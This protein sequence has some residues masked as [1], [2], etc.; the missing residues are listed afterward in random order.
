M[1]SDNFWHLITQIG[2]WA[3]SLSAIVFL[4][5]FVM[6]MLGGGK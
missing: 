4:V 1:P 6:I 5:G 2:A 3:T